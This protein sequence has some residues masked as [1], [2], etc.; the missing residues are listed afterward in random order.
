MMTRDEVLV[1]LLMIICSFASVLLLHWALSQALQACSISPT[2]P[3]TLLYFPDCLRLPECLQ[4]MNFQAEAT[5]CKEQWR[6]GKD[7]KKKKIHQKRLRHWRDTFIQKD[8]I[9]IIW[10]L[11]K[12]DVV[13]VYSHWKVIKT[14]RKSSDRL[15]GCTS[16]DKNFLMENLRQKER[17]RH[18]PH[19]KRSLRL[20]DNFSLRSKSISYLKRHRLIPWNRSCANFHKAPWTP[21]RNPLIIIWHDY[22]IYRPLV[23]IC[24]CQV[25]LPSQVGNNMVSKPK[26][27]WSKPISLEVANEQVFLYKLHWRLWLAVC[28]CFAEVALCFN[29][30]QCLH[31][32]SQ[33]HEDWH[34]TR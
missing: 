12:R 1:L 27:P 34:G 18:F 23:S 4:E 15:S 32:M 5:D 29:K 21:K 14:Q 17:K 16:W 3:T 13:N 19:S 28:L 7:S 8:S 30:I 24:K 9:H 6:M 26:S 33:E 22:G 10:P 25:M 11:D 20:W 31:D 2:L